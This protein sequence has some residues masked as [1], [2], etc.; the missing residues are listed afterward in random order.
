MFNLP[1]PSRKHVTGQPRLDAA[2]VEGNAFALTLAR[3]LHYPENEN[4]KRKV[5]LQV[6]MRGNAWGA[7]VCARPKMF[8]TKASKQRRVRRRLVYCIRIISML[9]DTNTPAYN[10]Q[11]H[12]SG[13]ARSPFCLRPHTAHQ[14]RTTRQPVAFVQLL[15]A[16]L[17]QRHNQV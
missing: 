7:C 16:N 15:Q 8:L 5:S 6:W 12:P 2:P 3:Q 1:F 11:R 10:R 9:P 4:G 14:H 13:A 17:R